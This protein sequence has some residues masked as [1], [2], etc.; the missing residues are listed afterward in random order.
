MGFALAEVLAEYGA[1]VSLIAGPV[2]IN[3]QHPSIKR[4]DITTADQMF[5][6]TLELFPDIEI[7]VLCAAVADFKPAHYSEEKIKKSGKDLSLR[8]VPT[9]D[10][11]KELGKQKKTSQFIAGFALESENEIENAQNKCIQKNMDMIVLN[12]INQIKGG[13]KSDM[14]EITLIDNQNNINKFE[15]KKKRDA[16]IDIIQKICEK[17]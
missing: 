6:K 17:I 12:S 9:P 7:A 3:A 10:I 2:F 1:K 5:V 14:N 13:I 4:Y 16:A 8:L 15:L 11:A